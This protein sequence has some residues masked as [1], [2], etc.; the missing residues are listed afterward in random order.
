MVAILFVLLSSGAQMH[1]P[2]ADPLACRI[3][4]AYLSR[5]GGDVIQA[6]CRERPRVVKVRGKR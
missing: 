3:E 4:A 5:A 6:E 1:L 2:Y